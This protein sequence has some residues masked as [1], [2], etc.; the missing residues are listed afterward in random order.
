MALHDLRG[1][2]RV[3]CADWIAREQIP[4]LVHETAQ[5][6]K[7]RKG[8]QGIGARALPTDLDEL[9]P[10]NGVVDGPADFRIRK[11]RFE[12]VKAQGDGPPIEVAVGWF[13][14]GPGRYIGIL[15]ENGLDIGRAQIQT[16]VHLVADQQLH[17]FVF[18]HVGQI[19]QAF[20][21]GESA[22]AR[23]SRPPVSPQI[24]DSLLRLGTDEPVGAADYGPAALEI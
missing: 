3:V 5:G 14:A 17:P 1:L 6:R 19:D 18:V 8:Q 4:D 22:K 2:G 7:I 16:G 10:V 21:A 23:L 11:R 24:P 20:Y 13:A 15:V 9:L 12:I